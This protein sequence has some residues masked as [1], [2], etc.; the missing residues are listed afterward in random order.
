VKRRKTAYGQAQKLDD[1]KEVLEKQ[2]IETDVLEKRVRSESRARS[3]KRE[4]S[5]SNN[6]L[7]T[8]EEE[9]EGR[10]ANRLREH[11][12]SRSRG[13]HREISVH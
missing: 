9:V 2:G 6:K 8:E 13:Y 5:E 12:R 3:L 7:V 4:R 1:L 10:L 11:S